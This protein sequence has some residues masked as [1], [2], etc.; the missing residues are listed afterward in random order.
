MKTFYLAFYGI[1]LHHKQLVGLYLTFKR[2]LCCN[3]ECYRTDK[4]RWPAIPLPNYLKKGTTKLFLIFN[5]FHQLF[6]TLNDALK[7]KTENFL[8]MRH[9]LDNRLCDVHIAHTKTCL[10]IYH[11]VI[12][13]TLMLQ[14]IN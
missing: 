13:V 11:S 2:D 1:F 3:R 6:R 7:Y 5:I 12:I 4:N 8:T 14:S 10:K 9:M